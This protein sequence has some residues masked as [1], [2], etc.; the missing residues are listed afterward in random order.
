LICN[1]AVNLFQVHSLLVKKLL[2]GLECSKLVE[3]NISR[4][5]SECVQ[6][7]DIEIDN[8]KYSYLRIGSL[9]SLN[10]LLVNDCVV[11][12]F[13]SESVN[14]WPA[15]FLLRINNVPIVYI[16][17]IG[18]IESPSFI[19][20]IS[21]D[22]SRNGFNVARFAD[23][24]VSF[25]AKFKR[26]SS[27]FF[28]RLFIFVH[29]FKKIDVL[30]VAN[31]NYYSQ[32]VMNKYNNIVSV[33]SLFYDVFLDKNY[34]VSDQYVVFL[35]SMVPYHEDQ[36]SLGYAV[37]D[38]HLYYSSIN[39]LFDW[40]EEILGKPVV[41]CAHPKYDMKNAKIDY[42]K[43][44]V[45]QYK[46]QEY[47]SK[48]SLVLFHES[49]SINSAFIYNKKVLQLT[50]QSFNAYVKMNIEQMYKRFGFSQFDFMG[51]DVDDLYKALD[52]C[53]AKNIKV[54]DFVRDC[55]VSSG[56]YNIPGYQQ[57]INYMC[58]EYNLNCNRK[59]C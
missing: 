53:S 54:D 50:S 36:V 4:V 46:T 7:I 2:R 39:R 48:S 25:G 20:L 49:S 35:D 42:N 33:N 10:K 32:G 45:L 22:E 5:Y 28:Y 34:I 37:I 41:V 3:L 15:T 12:S 23:A 51:G 18:L 43:R 19:G 11:I 52:L 24:A 38:P 58:I 9:F 40:L 30:F 14:D 1:N 16:S 31:K 13:F 29:F 47:V 27:S 21:S 55:I 26:I 17:N 56:Q 57:V 44:L 8:V 6:S 59:A